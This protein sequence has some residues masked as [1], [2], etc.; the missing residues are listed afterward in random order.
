MKVNTTESQ[1]NCMRLYFYSLSLIAIIPGLKL[2]LKKKQFII[3]EC[4]KYA[5]DYWNKNVFNIMHCTKIAASFI[6]FDTNYK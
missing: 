3:W 1:Y 6:V 2:G 5:K 4:L